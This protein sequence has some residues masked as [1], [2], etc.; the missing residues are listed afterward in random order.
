MTF[1]EPLV[2]AAIVHKTAILAPAMQANC[3]EFFTLPLPFMNRCREMLDAVDVSGA[4]RSLML[5]SYPLLDPEMPR[6]SGHQSRL[7]QAVL[8]FA[9]NDRETICNAICL[10]GF[11]VRRG[12][13]RTP[14]RRVPINVRVPAGSLAGCDHG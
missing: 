10:I 6:H 11:P 14:D 9:A 1:A 7:R 3:L 5:F 4:H 2:A 12:F 13:A 8:K